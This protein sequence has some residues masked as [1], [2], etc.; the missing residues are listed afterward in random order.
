MRIA[1]VPDNILIQIAADLRF[2]LYE[3]KRH[4]KGNC[5]WVTFQL[6]PTVHSLKYKR[7]TPTGRNVWAI[8]WHGHKAFF[9][10]LFKLCPE[11]DVQVGYYVRLHWRGSE[12]Y[13]PDQA[14][15]IIG[16]RKFPAALSECCHCND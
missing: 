16:S 6:K 9:D 15:A 10:M 12:E 1:K 14:D 4:T 7:T 13:K 2:D 3:F 5:K 8:C 11:A